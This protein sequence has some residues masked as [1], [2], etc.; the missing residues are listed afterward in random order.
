MKQELIDALT[1]AMTIKSEAGD[2]APD[3]EDV[4]DVHDIVCEHYGLL[5]ADDKTEAP[6]RDL[7]NAARPLIKYI[8]ENHNSYS[9]AIVTSSSVEV[10]DRTASIPNIDDFL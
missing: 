4:K 1:K 9:S 6:L 5:S 2:L 3:W 8:N 10:L 7:E